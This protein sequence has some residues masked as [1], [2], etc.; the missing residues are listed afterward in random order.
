V[1][2]VIPVKK[3][4]A[5]AGGAILG[6]VKKERPRLLMNAAGFA[7][8][9]NRAGSDAITK[10]LLASLKATAEKIIELPELVQVRG[11]AAA[12]NNPGAKVIFRMSTLGTLNYVDGDPRWKDYAV[13]EL[14][15]MSMFTNWHPGE[16]K[17]CAQFVWGMSVGYD[18]FRTS[19]NPEQAAKI[20]KALIELG[21]DALM[22]QL[23]GEPLPV[24]TTRPEP[25][26]APAS[27]PDPKTAR[28]IVEGREPDAEEMSAAGALLLAAIALADEESSLATQAANL[29]H[30]DLR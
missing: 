1:V 3:F 20:K 23:K 14:I 21:V 7:A 13:R 15:S 18:M 24:T 17:S 6:T 29:R 10:N 2:T 19:M 30:E 4:K 25:G 5:P 28:T 9:K 11:E 26:Q 27:K 8:L 22:A 12:N 16:M